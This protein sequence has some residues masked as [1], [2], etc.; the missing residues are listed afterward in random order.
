MNENNGIISIERNASKYPIVNKPKLFSNV[1]DNPTRTNAME[2]I[3]TTIKT[4]NGVVDFFKKS[5]Q[6]HPR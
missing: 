1:S 3:A 2:I 4:N 6:K 5:P